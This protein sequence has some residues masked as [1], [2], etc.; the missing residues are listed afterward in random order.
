MSAPFLIF[1]TDARIVAGLGIAAG[2]LAIYAA[3]KIEG[4]TRETWKLAGEVVTH[5]LNPTSPDNLAYRG[6]NSVGKIISADPQFSLGVWAWELLN[7]SQV[8][9][10][11]GDLYNPTQQVR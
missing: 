9:R 11:R 3:R 1:G 4:E 10:E 6:V 7:P 8:A 5:E 2:V